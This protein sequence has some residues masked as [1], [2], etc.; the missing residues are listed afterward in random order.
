MPQGAV[1]LEF[2]VKM[3][4]VFKFGVPPELKLSQDESMI[5][6][7]TRTIV[8]EGYTGITVKDRTWATYLKPPYLYGILLS[9]TE[10]QNSYEEPIQAV[11][12]A[13]NPEG[14]ITS[15]QLSELYQE[16]LSRTG[17]HL[18]EQLSEQP[19][20]QMILESLRQSQRTLRPIWSLE[21]GYRYPSIEKL[22]EK[23]TEET[24]SLLEA[25][26]NA[27]LLLSR[28]GGNIA[29]CPKCSSHRVVLH[30]I[31][32]KCGL[33]TLESGIALE[34]FTCNHTNFIEAFSS[35]TGLICPRCQAFLIPR[36]Y[37]TLGKVFHCTTCDSFPRETEKML[38]CLTCKVTFSTDQAK[39]VPVYYYL[40]PPESSS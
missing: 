18:R 23:P 2:D 40:A 3:G 10:P 35:P 28:I 33:P 38:G 31:C 20:V 27:A 5:L 39:Y 36:T 11:L 24:N 34:H 13:Y 32:P 25:M 22:I 19:E 6:F 17:Q 15:E 4:P 14:E 16:I 30:S 12:G 37:R 7:S 21:N 8:D 26:M 1:L 9:P 29:I